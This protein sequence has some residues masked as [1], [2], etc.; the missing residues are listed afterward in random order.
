M[1]RKIFK[2]IKVFLL[3]SKLL[4]FLWSQFSSY[5]KEFKSCEHWH[6]QPF[7]LGG[8]QCSELSFPYL[9]F[10]HF[11]LQMGDI[12]KTWKGMVPPLPLPTPTHLWLLGKDKQIW[13]VTERNC[14]KLLM[15]PRNISPVA[16]CLKGA[17][18]AEWI[19]AKGSVI[20]PSIRPESWWFVSLHCSLIYDFL[21]LDLSA[22]FNFSRFGS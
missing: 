14:I 19:V 12:W 4:L 22:L 7:S 8:K 2:V 15:L 5:C 13:M 17:F 10:G 20:S 21:L 16:K 1:E 9:K 6:R 11:E 18:K 3:L